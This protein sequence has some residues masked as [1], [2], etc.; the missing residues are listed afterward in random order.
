MEL[1]VPGQEDHAAV[2]ALRR[3]SVSDAVREAFREGPD[4]RVGGDVVRLEAEAALADEA[5]AFAFDEHWLRD[6]VELRVFVLPTEVPSLHERVSDHRPRGKGGEEGERLPQLAELVVRLRRDELAVDLLVRS[7]H[8]D[9]QLRRESALRVHPSQDRGSRAVRHEERGDVPSLE[10]VDHLAEPLV[11]RRFARQADRHVRGVPRLQ[12]PF[13]AHVRISVVAAQQLPLRPDRF[14]YD[15]GRVVRLEQAVRSP[16]LRAPAELTREVARVHGRRHLEAPVAFD[17]V[18]GLLVAADAF[19]Q[20]GLRPVAELDAAVLPDDAVP[21]PLE[22]VLLLRVHPPRH[23]P[24]GLKGFRASES[25][26]LPGPVRGA[27]KRT[28]IDLPRMELDRPERV[29]LREERLERTQ[30][31]GEAQVVDLQGSML[32][33]ERPRDVRRENRFDP[34][35]AHSGSTNG[36]V[37]FVMISASSRASRRPTMLRWRLPGSRVVRLALV[38]RVEPSGRR[39]ARFRM[40]DLGGLFKEMLDRVARLRLIQEE[41]DLSF[42]E[43]QLG[44][45]LDSELLVAGKQ[46][47]QDRQDIGPHERLRGMQVAG[48]LARDRIAGA[49]LRPGS[50]HL[51]QVVRKLELSAARPASPGH[52]HAARH[53]LAR[54]RPQPVALPS[55]DPAQEDV[56]SAQDI[57]TP[58]EVVRSAEL[59]RQVLID[60]QDEILRRLVEVSDRLAGPP[61]IARPQDFLDDREDRELAVPIAQRL[62]RRRADLLPADRNGLEVV[63]GR[64]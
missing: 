15:E 19:R 21:L 36:K 55:T 35:T 25:L 24:F 44:R 5:V 3:W 18:E 1:S 59:V 10:L 31:V 27:S 26:G 17:P 22:D 12:E 2:L 34:S 56:G 49:A 51:N 40:G 29:L 57:V 45:Q 47:F 54:V 32:V 16:L 23:A 7:G 63:D 8:G 11:E 60:P 42:I 41:R 14:V 30:I 48:E 28:E 37:Y 6:A 61:R 53:E 38:E 50:R 58:G 4:G 62:R 64:S 33:H 20:A 9:V 43:A 52:R 39:L 46:G 13:P